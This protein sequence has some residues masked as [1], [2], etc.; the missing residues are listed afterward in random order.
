M[1]RARVSEYWTYAW[2]LHAEL[3]A[4]MHQL[5]RAQLVLNCHDVF[6]NVLVLPHV[7]LEHLVLFS[8]GLTANRLLRRAFAEL[9]LSLQLGLTQLLRLF[10]LLEPDA[11]VFLQPPVFFL[12]PRQ[13]LLLDR[14]APEVLVSAILVQLRDGLLGRVGR[15][16]GDQWTNPYV[17][18]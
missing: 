1:S 8:V 10:L 3:L 9:E 12:L 16:R 2:V 5:V 17:E 14:V 18:R 7:L 13:V 6:I 11:L 4:L 15:A